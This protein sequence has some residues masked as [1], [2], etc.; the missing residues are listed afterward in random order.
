MLFLSNSIVIKKSITEIIMKTKYYQRPSSYLRVSIIQMFL[1][2]IVLESIVF[3]KTDGE[4][5]YRWIYS[6]YR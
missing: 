4:K 6:I 5:H 2:M 1:T 3:F